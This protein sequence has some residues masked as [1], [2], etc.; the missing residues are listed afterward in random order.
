MTA[1]YVPEGIA[2]PAIVAALGARGTFTASLMSLINPHC[3]PFRFADIVIAGGL[4]KDIK[5]KVRCASP[6]SLLSTRPMTDRDTNTVHPL[7]T[8]GLLGRRRGPQ[9]RRHPHRFP[10]VCLRRGLGQDQLTVEA[11]K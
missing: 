4:H 11:V 7:R 2:P 9:G 5:A 6:L 1:V 10:A 3:F 8:H